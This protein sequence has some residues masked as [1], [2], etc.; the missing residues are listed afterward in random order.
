MVMSPASLA[1]R[2]S[3]HPPLARMALVRFWMS[4]AGSSREVAFIRRAQEEL[5]CK[6]LVDKVSGIINLYIGATRQGLTAVLKCDGFPRL[7]AGKADVTDPSLGSGRG[8][9]KSF[10][11]QI[12]VTGTEVG[13]ICP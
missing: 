11:G 2:L 5:Y 13:Q 8:V 1:P 9:F 4:G 3:T 12:H 10:D 7:G 6:P